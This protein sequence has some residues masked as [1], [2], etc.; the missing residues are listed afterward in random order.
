MILRYGFLRQLCAAAALLVPVLAAG[1]GDSPT[2]A[3]PSFSQT[4]LR[5]GTGT[6][7]V[8]GN[9][10][11]VFYTGW[12]YDPARP[13]QKGLQFDTNVGGTAFSFVL[14]ADQVIDGWDQGL[15]G[16][17]AGG[18]RRLVIPPS[19]AYGSVRNGPIPPNSTL[20]FDVEVTKIE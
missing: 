3:P 7:A 5:A 18:I 13:D 12:L 19:L 10:L 11:T 20:V 15:T 17:R 9:T 2:M 16:V 4:D 1:C 6:G 8:N 14:G